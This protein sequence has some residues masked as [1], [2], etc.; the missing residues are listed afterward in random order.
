MNPGLRA[1]I[2]SASSIEAL[3]AL[4]REFR[5]QVRQVVADGHEAAQVTAC[6]SET[7]DALCARIVELEGEAARLDIE[8]CWIVM[9]SQGRREQ[10]L[11]TDQDN[12]IIFS[13]PGDAEAARRALCTSARRIN[14]QMSRCGIPLCR[15]NI[16]G[17]NPQ[18][19]LTL[20]EWKTRF[21]S[22]LDFGHPEA[23]LN[24]AIF[25]D[26]RPLVGAVALASDLRAWLA[27]RSRDHTRFLLQLTCSALE[28]R[29][30]LGL[31]DRFIL[32]KHG[33][34]A[35]AIDLKVNGV[36]P[37]VDAARVYG[38]AGGVLDTGTIARFEGAAA[39]SLMNVAQSRVWIE[40]FSSLQKLRLRAQART[41]NAPTASANVVDPDHLS[42]D[43]R[44]TL[45]HALRQ[46]QRLQQWLTRDF[47]GLT[48]GLGA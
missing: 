46:A 47:A 28:N 36:T 8:H 22:W 32:S 43:E 38:L 13:T 39:A 42:P 27:Q 34:V 40:A 4:S 9:G 37:F 16:M 17:G 7:N 6:I 48:P 44:R 41:M 5:E 31:F 3:A 24:A 15:G 30:P 26:F 19:C 29:P 2:D 45:K 23:L 1:A 21:A 18:W 33:D 11:H 14:E 25:F 10:T 12:A 20:A 35:H